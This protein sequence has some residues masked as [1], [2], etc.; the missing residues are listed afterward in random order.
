MKYATVIFS[1]FLASHAW[2]DGIPRTAS[3]KPLI[4]GYYDSGTL[5]PVD[6]PEEFGEE[7]FM[8]R[9]RAAQIANRVAER[10]A[11]GQS[12]CASS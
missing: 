8:T 10:K 1:V 3:G 6:R 12:E 9:E 11:R 5:T 7:K 4:E 2:S